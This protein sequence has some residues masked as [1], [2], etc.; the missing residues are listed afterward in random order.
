MVAK[1]DI[2]PAERGSAAGELLRI[3]GVGFGLAVVVGGVVGQGI[4]R[5]PGIVAG[6]LPNDLDPRR[7]DRRRADHPRRRLRD[8]RARRIAAARRR[9]L[10]VCRARLRPDRRHDARLGR[11]D[12]LHPRHF[13][14]L[15]GVCRIYAAARPCDRA[16]NRDA[17]RPPHRCR[18]AG[19][20]G[21]NPNVRREPG[22]RQC[23]QRPRPVPV[24][25]P[26]VAR[27]QPWSRRARSGRH[28]RARD[29]HARDRDARRRD[30]LRRLERKRLFLRGDP[31]TGAQPGSGDVR[32][33]PAWSWCSMSP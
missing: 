32:R 18:G 24:D 12:E 27:A 19:Q 21:W 31:R 25:R 2:L 16:S 13:L 3:L 14:R 23:G 17:R 26:L 33:N 7:L 10:C 15:G 28:S 5:T 11:L 22:A 29:R 30:Y 4:M 6:A 20:L 9:S 8:R 1:P